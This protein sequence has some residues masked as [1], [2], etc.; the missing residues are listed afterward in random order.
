V[1]HIGVSL[2]T[3]DLNGYVGHRGPARLETIDEVVH[4]F[5]AFAIYLFM[6]LFTR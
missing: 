4:G 2:W 1:L 3:G 6:G 5:E